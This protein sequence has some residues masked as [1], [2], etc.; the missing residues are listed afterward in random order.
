MIA[1][2]LTKSKY[3]ND[4]SGIGA[5]MYGGRWNSKGVR[6]LYTSQS[7]AL[8]ATEVAVHVPFGIVPEDYF[9]QTILFP[10]GSM[11]EVA[12]DA[13]PDKWNRFPH[14]SETKEVGDAFVNSGKLLVL[15][16]PSAVIQDEFNYLLN[17]LHPLFR[18]VIIQSIEPFRF[19]RRLFA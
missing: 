8:C 11:I 2:R 4:I 6:M 14:I 13:L 10:E 12:I 17:P 3:K 18:E 15:K 7:R 19:D 1:Y 16:A 5:E 9:L